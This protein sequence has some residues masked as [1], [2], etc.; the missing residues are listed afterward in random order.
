MQIEQSNGSIKLTVKTQGGRN[1]RT[2][3][4]GDNLCH[5]CQASKEADQRDKQKNHSDLPTGYRFEAR[6]KSKKRLI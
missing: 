6:N 3:S 1:K 2:R 5:N 4:N